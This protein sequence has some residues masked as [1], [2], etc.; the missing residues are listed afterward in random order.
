MSEFGLTGAAYHNTGEHWKARKALDIAL[1]LAKELESLGKPH[2][3]EA[4]TLV[5][6][7]DS[8]FFHNPKNLDKAVGCYKQARK[9]LAFKKGQD[10][11]CQEMARIRVCT[12]LLKAKEELRSSLKEEPDQEIKELVEEILCLIRSH[13]NRACKHHEH[14]ARRLTEYTEKQIQRKIEQ[15]RKQPIS[16]QR[17]RQAQQAPPKEPETR[18]DED[19]GHTLELIKAR[20]GSKLKKCVR[21]HKE[22]ITQL[23]PLVVD[24]RCK[25]LTKLVRTRA[26]QFS[27][28]AVQAKDITSTDQAQNLQPCLISLTWIL[29][30]YKESLVKLQEMEL[31]LATSD[32]NE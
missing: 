17:Q 12:K 18:F 24:I 1:G 16:S 20:A 25:E 31:V 21:D 29:E 14:S 27:I 7:G 26:P 11:D 23:Q 15:E 6:L 9:R 22:V 8:Y 10:A 3:T 19:T 28:P 4:P 5:H 30:Q 2:H 13:F 32:L